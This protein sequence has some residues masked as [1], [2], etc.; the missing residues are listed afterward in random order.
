MRTRPWPLPGRAW[1]GETL[2]HANSTSS[3]T[4]QIVSRET[5]HKLC[6]GSWLRYVPAG[7]EGTQGR[8]HYLVLAGV[9]RFSLY[10]NAFSVYGKAC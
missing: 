7:D 3:S 1:V 6:A 10:L 4:S 5:G 9:G 8:A 2:L